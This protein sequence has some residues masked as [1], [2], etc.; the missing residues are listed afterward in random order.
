MNETLDIMYLLHIYEY[1]LWLT[2]VYCVGH[3]VKHTVFC[4][5]NYKEITDMGIYWK[6]STLY[7]LYIPLIYFVPR[8]P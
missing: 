4:Y 1:I 3:K 5:N 8:R 6:Y 7:F 2:F